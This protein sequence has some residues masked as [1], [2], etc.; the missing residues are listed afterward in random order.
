MCFPLSVTCYLLQFHSE[1]FTLINKHYSSSDVHHDVAGD[2]K[3]IVY[4][5]ARSNSVKPVVSDEWSTDSFTM[6]QSVAFHYPLTTY[7]LAIANPEGT[8]FQPKSCFSSFQL[9]LHGQR[10]ISLVV[11]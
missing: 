4:P 2:Y 9:V 10:P 6:W 7:P 1:V 3:L 11:L 5:Y 8:L